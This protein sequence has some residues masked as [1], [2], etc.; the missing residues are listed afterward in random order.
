MLLRLARSHA[1]CSA[2][3]LSLPACAHPSPL[4]SSP[5]PLLTLSRRLS[6]PSS[7]LLPPLNLHSSLLPASSPKPTPR[8]VDALLRRHLTSRS[9][10][11][12]EA[13]EAHESRNLSLGACMLAIAL[14]T[15]GL[16]YASVPLYR[17]FC[18]ATGFGGT[19]KTHGGSGSSDDELEYNLPK[20]PSALPNNRSLKVQHAQAASSSP[21]PDDERCEGDAGTDRTIHLP[22]F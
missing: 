1:L 9:D 14:F 13:R 7:S 5:S 21:S 22:I 19:V 15:A 11:T 8:R 2:R 18:Q 6:L 10:R 4:L 17:M 20:D 3:R 16:S 12:S